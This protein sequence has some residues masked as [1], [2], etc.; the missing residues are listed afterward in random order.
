MK[1]LPV[2]AAVL[3]AGLGVAPTAEAAPDVHCRLSTAVEEVAGLSQLPRELRS[4][5][6]PMADVGAPF[7]ATD[8]V[9]DG[10]LPFRR[11]IR[12]GHRG[13]DW[14]VWYEHGGIT[15]SW[16]ALVARLSGAG[17]PPTVLANAGTI[18]DTLCALTDGVYAGQVPPYPDGTWAVQS[19]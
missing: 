13:D 12:A 16:Q 4:Y 14:F 5:L 17:D 11:L 3:I 15:Y 9:T 2:F 10:S 6:G 8:A 7:N 18:S 19:P 1:V